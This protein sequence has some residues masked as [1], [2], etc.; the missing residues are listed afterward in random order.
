MEK[1]ISYTVL[2]LTLVSCSADNSPRRISSTDNTKSSQNSS[3]NNNTVDSLNNENE[4]SFKIDELNSE[5]QFKITNQDEGES[6]DIMVV[7]KELPIVNEQRDNYV[8][9]WPRSVGAVG[10]SITKALFA[11]TRNRKSFSSS[12]AVTDIL[13]LSDFKMSKVHKYEDTSSYGW[14]RGKKVN[15]LVNLIETTTKNKDSVTSINVAVSGKTSFDAGRN[16]IPRLRQYMT[17]LNKAQKYPD[18]ITVLTGAND[19]CE[20]TYKRRQVNN[21]LYVP[22]RNAL[23]SSPQTVVSII[24]IP[25][26]HKIYP[27]LHKVESYHY[28][29][30]FLK[31]KKVSCEKMWKRTG[32]CKRVLD[33]QNLRQVEQD[34]NN[35]NEDLANLYMNLKEEFPNRVMRTREL[36]IEKIDKE[37]MGIDCFHPNRYGQNKLAREVYTDYK[38]QIMKIK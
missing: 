16:Q 29:N 17:Q 4:N 1:C 33:G 11:S 14:I 5:N 24:S 36:S 19:I 32:F 26:M 7:Q 22:L 30:L 10:D 37:N 25:Q 6:K 34:V 12:G 31:K 8:P 27:T 20:G 9:R 38:M 23:L 28:R 35:L 3:I 2:F 18:L 13:K 15:S 21:N